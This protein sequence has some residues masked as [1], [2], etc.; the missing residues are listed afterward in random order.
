MARRQVH[1]GATRV[2]LL[3]QQHGSGPA[4]HVLFNL[5][6][7]QKASRARLQR[8]VHLL[9][10]MHKRRDI[11]TIHAEVRKPRTEP[12]RSPPEHPQEPDQAGSTPQ[13][14]PGATA[15]VHS[16][17]VYIGSPLVSPETQ[18]HL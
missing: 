10:R 4:D 6:Y 16:Y 8:Q 13:T 3:H 7:M 1:I 11:A 2:R 17:A 12:N 14:E 15:Y 18:I 5:P 9:S